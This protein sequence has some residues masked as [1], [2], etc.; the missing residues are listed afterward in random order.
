MPQPPTSSQELAP[1]G[2]SKG[3]SVNFS[4][5]G[6]TGQGESAWF[7][8][9]LR[10]TLERHGHQFVK[11]PHCAS[12]VLNFVDLDDPKPFRRRSHAIFVAAVTPVDP[13]FGGLMEKGYPLLV[14]SL[15]NL[16]I[17]LVPEG[18]PLPTAHFVTPELG[19]FVVEGGQEPERYMDAVYERIRP[20]ATSR[21][22]LENVFEPDLERGLWD[23]DDVT[24]SLF[25]AG[26]R[27]SEL[28]LL[29]A[30]FPVEE[31][32]GER[33]QREF[34]LL[35]GV[36]GRSFGNLSAR[37]DEDRFWM[38]ASGVDKS[39]LRKV[40]RDILLV[41]SYDPKR[42]AMILSV[43]ADVEPRRVSVDAIEHWMIYKE[44]PK[45]AAILHV[46]AWMDGAPS[47]EF[48]YPC[49]SYELGAA[50]ARIVRE[51]PEPRK[52][53]VGLKNHGLTI[54][55][56]SMGEILRRV[57]GKIYRPVPMS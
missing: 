24:R 2:P 7:R 17:G 48:T 22:V 55:G 57:D 27:L 49:G 4:Y 43:P 12:L 52:A 14:R 8:D 19:H 42:N 40:G 5:F 35:Y 3:T 41:K 33:D 38:S 23:G 15:C 30:P 32:L 51:S 46:H 26:R 53:V 34:K 10:K 18:A 20:L 31:Y 37:L 50:V 54:L 28:D 39:N 56:E 1:S 13:P 45:V 11:D 29:P 16:L 44:H 21:L 47:T 25:E 9:D 36:G 6:Q